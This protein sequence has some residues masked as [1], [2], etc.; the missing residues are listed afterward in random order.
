M[1]NLRMDVFNI[2]SLSA[3]MRRTGATRA[4]GSGSLEALCALL[5]PSA[6][7]A[8]AWS[9]DSLSGDHVGSIGPLPKWEMRSSVRNEVSPHAASPI[10]LFLTPDEGGWPWAALARPW[11]LPIWSGQSVNAAEVRDRACARLRP[12]SRPEIGTTAPSN[13]ATGSLRGRF[14][15]PSG[16]SAEI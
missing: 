6:I 11:S 16:K 7:A 13:V 12:V 9:R 14:R 2:L 5:A 15:L 1:S 10:A 4:R 3:A 8:S